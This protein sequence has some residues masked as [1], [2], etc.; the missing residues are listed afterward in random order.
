MEL[1][2]S[3][4]LEEMI[5][6]ETAGMQTTSRSI[7]LA[8]ITIP[9]YLTAMM[10]TEDLVFAHTVEGMYFKA[11]RSHLTPSLK[12]RLR[13]TGIDLDQKLQIGYPREAWGA[14]LRVTAQELNPT[15]TP[16]EAH[17]RL[18]ELF[19]EGYTDTFLGKAMLGILRVVGPMRALARMP[20]NLRSGSNY[21][22]CQFEKLGPFQ[23]R[24]TVNEVDQ[25]PA[26][27]IALAMRARRERGPGGSGGALRQLRTSSHRLSTSR[28]TWTPW[29]QL[30]QTF[31]LSWTGLLC[32]AG[33]EP[34]RSKGHLMSRSAK[35][36]AG[37]IGNETPTGTELDRSEQSRAQWASGHDL[38]GILRGGSEDF[39]GF[40]RRLVRLGGEYGLSSS[41]TPSMMTEGAAR[42]K[43]KIAWSA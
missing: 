25:M 23:A 40:R 28:P 7:P 20:Q 5:W 4:G 39:D 8:E 37:R 42:E 27:P 6:A 18:G 36:G 9:C 11:L 32:R 38:R 13:Q 26:A 34:C 41:F 16:Q 35:P 29:M 43:P 24:L 14:C 3:L 21:L 2:P 17:R 22:E 31:L 12:A 10:R 15:L 1:R 19:F 33:C 30:P